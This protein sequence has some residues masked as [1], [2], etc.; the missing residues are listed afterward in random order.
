MSGALVI[1]DLTVAYTSGDYVVKPVDGFSCEV[2]DGELA[3][4]LGPSG[5]G[6]TTL[7]SCL[8][9]ILRPT[10]GSIHH[11]ALEIT[12]LTGKAL[13]EYRR[14]GVGI[15]FQAFNLIPSLTAFDNVMLPMRNARVPNEDARSRARELL[16]EMN[17]GDRSGHMPGELSGGQ[18]QRVA[19][20]RALALEPPLLLADEP[21]AHLDYVQVES[22]LRILRRL[23]EP[24]RILVIVTHDERLLPLADHVIE[25]VPH[26]PV[27]PESPV[28]RRLEA[29]ETLFDEGDASDLIY[30]VDAGVLEI[31]RTSS[32]GKI[33]AIAERGPGECFG[34]MGPLFGLPRSAAARARTVVHLT[35]YSVRDFRETM[36]I[37]RLDGLV[38]HRGNGSRTTTNRGQ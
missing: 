34:E 26:R 27:S 6:K 14:H 31:L 3:L 32:S 25:L 23:A 38:R 22:M 36:G 11:G 1:D 17:L 16:D 2:A 15:V 24:G 30:M 5:S 9:G 20:A 19:I 37:E 35:G 29:G 7:L 33:E 8:A 4:L 13:T 12:S 18:Q 10:S 28:E 21:T